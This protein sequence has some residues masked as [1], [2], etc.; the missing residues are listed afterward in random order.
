MKQRLDYLAK[1][2]SLLKIKANDNEQYSRKNNIRIYG[3]EEKPHENP[4]EVV[5][6]LVN[7]K[8]KIRYSI[9]ST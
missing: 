4:K 9:S 1:E 6:A 7:D 8:L 5:T 2:I 3:L